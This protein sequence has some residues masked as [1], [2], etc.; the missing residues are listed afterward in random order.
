MVRFFLFTNT[1]FVLKHIQFRL[2]F[3]FLVFFRRL[4]THFDAQFISSLSFFV[5]YDSSLLSIYINWNQFICNRSLKCNSCI[6]W[7]V[8]MLLLLLLFLLSKR[9]KIWFRSL[10]FVENIYSLLFRYPCCS[11]IWFRAFFHFSQF[12][13]TNQCFA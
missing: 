9:K 5:F 4:L 10:I 13:I 3:P 6:L 2:S 12:C 11:N 7:T 1:K 8:Y